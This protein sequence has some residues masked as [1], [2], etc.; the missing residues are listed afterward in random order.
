MLSTF[1]VSPPLP[2][3]S[4]SL[5]L[6]LWGC[7]STT[8]SCLSGLLIIYPGSSSPY[9][10]NGL[11]SPW[12]QIRESFATYRGEAM[13]TLY[14]LFGWWFSPWELLMG[15]VGWYCSSYEVVNP[16]SFDSPC[17]NSSMGVSVFSPVFGSAHLHQYFSGSGRAFQGTAILDSCQ[18]ASTSWLQQ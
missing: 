16:F 5:P 15:L 18:Q 4:S 14:I 6:S 2:P 3:L 9:R 11:Q 7:S 8:G 10:T 13:G 12:C 1:P 17:P